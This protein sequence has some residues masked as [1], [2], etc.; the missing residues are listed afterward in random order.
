MLSKDGIKEH[1]NKIECLEMKRQ[2]IINIQKEKKELETEIKDRLIGDNETILVII[3]YVHKMKEKDDR[4]RHEIHSL[5]QNILS[6]KRWKE[7]LTSISLHNCNI[8]S[9]FKDTSSDAFKVMTKFSQESHRRK[10]EIEGSNWLVHISLFSDDDT[11]MTI[12]DESSAVNRH[13]KI[14]KL[15]KIAR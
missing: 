7:L 9:M 14:S 4:D 2:Q 1:Q 10:G 3:N 13:G 6:S 11:T 15:I 8:R 12:Y 5:M